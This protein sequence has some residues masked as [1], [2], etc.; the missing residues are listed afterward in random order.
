MTDQPTAVN[1]TAAA[2]AN[3]QQPTMQPYA[4]YPGPYGQ[5]IPHPYADPQG[6]AG[7]PPVDRNW[8][9]SKLG[10]HAC[11]LVFGIITLALSLTVPRDT[12]ASELFLAGSVPVAIACIIWALAEGITRIVR[13][14]K[15]G[16]HPGAHVAVSLLIWLAAAWVVAL[17]G[18]VLI[19][20]NDSEPR[21]RRPS[22]RYDDDYP[23]LDADSWFRGG[24]ALAKAAAVFTL[25]L[26][27]VQ[28]ILFVGA[29][30]DTHKR[31]RAAYR[32]IVYYQPAPQWAP[33]PTGNGI[34]MQNQASTAERGFAEPKAPESAAQPAPQRQPT[35]SE[36][37]PPAT[38]A[39]N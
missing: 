38:D 23:E 25:L 4:P 22:S 30:V 14:F 19:A 10:L 28:F 36:Y 35:V 12:W 37:Y 32:P 34:P 7:R 16:I 3:H 5:A 26:W 11:S 1:T 27:L 39:R 18:A 15:A 31:R 13:K 2:H 6:H 33:A 17:E 9:I 21:R 24:R 8:E 20:V 29:C